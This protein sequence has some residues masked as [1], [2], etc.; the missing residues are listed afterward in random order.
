[1][2]E[3]RARWR[4]A[5]R[6]PGG[7][8][9]VWFISSVSSVVR[10]ARVHAVHVEVARDVGAGQAEVARRGHDVGQAALVEQVQV[11]VGVRR[12]GRAAVV[13]REAH[14]H[15]VP[16]QRANGLADRVRLGHRL[17]TALS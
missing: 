13:R 14:R 11:D 10:V 16:Q 7:G 12:A 1:M 15:P 2:P 6:A 17:F 9:S 4:A 3:R 5:R 8:S